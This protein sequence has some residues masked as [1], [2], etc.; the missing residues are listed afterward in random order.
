ML[1]HSLSIF[2]DTA[3]GS[4]AG[5]DHSTRRSDLD[6]LAEEMMSTES[7]ATPHR[8][9]QRGVLQR[10]KHSTLGLLAATTTQNTISAEVLGYAIKGRSSWAGSPPDEDLG[11]TPLD[12]QFLLDLASTYP[13]GMLWSFEES[14]I[15][16]PIEGGAPLESSN[17][18]PRARRAPTRARREAEAELLREHFSGV[19]QLLFAPLHDLS[20]GWSSAG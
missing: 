14:G 9:Q 7:T 5:L 13:E 10:R 2:L 16:F 4:L 17:L 15:M 12:E 19:R 20:L 1:T 18:R 11:F 8:T 3:I 6:H